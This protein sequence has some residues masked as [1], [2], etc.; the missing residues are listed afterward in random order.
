MPSAINVF[1]NFN[2]WDRLLLLIS[3][4]IFIFKVLKIYATAAIPFIRWVS[5]KTMKWFIARWVFTL[6][7]KLTLFVFCV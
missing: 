5:H 4:L 2:R 3:I 6:S 1:R 7:I